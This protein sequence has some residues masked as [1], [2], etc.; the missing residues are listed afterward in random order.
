MIKTYAQK[1]KSCYVDC[2]FLR[3][4]SE[5]RPFNHPSQSTTMDHDDT[6]ADPV[7]LGMCIAGL[8]LQVTE[9]VLSGLEDSKTTAV[10]RAKIE[11]QHCLEIPSQN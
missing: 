6:I 1:Q 10:M 4:A 3:L 11:M 9:M 5:V 8:L 7:C 2:C